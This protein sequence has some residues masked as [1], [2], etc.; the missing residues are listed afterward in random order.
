MAL[1]KLFQGLGVWDFLWLRARGFGLS[2]KQY[3]T[4][5]TCNSANSIRIS[6]RELPHP[7]TR[8]EKLLHARVLATEFASRQLRQ[9][10]MKQCVDC[11]RCVPRR[12]PHIPSP[13]IEGARRPRTSTSANSSARPEKHPQALNYEAPPQNMTEATLR[14]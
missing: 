11:Y 12:K 8:S 5:L 6:L 10:H 4:H 9:R 1:W 13:K 2:Q 7:G 3:S 14:P